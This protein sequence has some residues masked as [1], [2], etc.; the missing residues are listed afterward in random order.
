MITKKLL[1]FCHLVLAV[2]AAPARRASAAGSLEVG[3]PPP[4]PRTGQPKTRPPDKPTPLVTIDYYEP[5]AVPY[6]YAYFIDTSGQLHSMR[7]YPTRATDMHA[8][9]TSVGTDMAEPK[10]TREAWRIVIQNPT[11]LKLRLTRVRIVRTDYRPLPERYVCVWKQKG[12]VTPKSVDIGLGSTDLEWSMLPDGGQATLAPGEDPLILLA[13]IVKADPGIYR[14]QVVVDAAPSLG[15]PATTVAAGAL[16]LFVPDRTAGH[17]VHTIGPTDHTED[18]VRRI[19][20]MSPEPFRKLAADSQSQSWKINLA[21][22]LEIL[23]ATKERDDEAFLKVMRAWKDLSTTSAREGDDAESKQAN[24]KNQ[25]IDRSKVGITLAM[26]LESEGRLAEAAD[27]LRQYRIDRPED[28]MAA[29]RLMSDYLTAH[30]LNAATKLWADLQHDPIRRRLGWFA[31]GLALA[32]ATNDSR[33]ADELVKDSRTLFPDDLGLLQYRLPITATVAN[34]PALL[35]EFKSFCGY[36]DYLPD[37][38]D[39]LKF[40]AQLAATLDGVTGLPTRG[41]ADE[42]RQVL[43]RCPAWIVRL[44]RTEGRL[45]PFLPELRLPPDVST[46]KAIPNDEWLPLGTSLAMSGRLDAAAALLEKE[47][48]LRPDDPELADVLSDVYIRVGR[49]D[50][51][52]RVLEHALA[53][54]GASQELVER[55]IGKSILIAHQKDDITIVTRLYNAFGV[56]SQTRASGAPKAS[57]RIR[58]LLR[59]T[60]EIAIA[61]FE[62]LPRDFVDWFRSDPQELLGGYTPDSM[63]VVVAL[64]QAIGNQ[65]QGIAPLS[66]GMGRVPRELTTVLW[67]SYLHLNPQLVPNRYLSIDEEKRAGQASLVSFAQAT[68]AALVKNSPSLTVFFVRWRGGISFGMSHDGIDEVVDGGANIPLK[69]WSETHLSDAEGART[70]VYLVPLRGKAF[71]AQIALHEAFAAGL[72]HYDIVEAKKLVAAVTKDDPTDPSAYWLTA[73]LEAIDGAPAK[74]LAAVSRGILLDPL[75]QPLQSLKLACEEAAARRPR[76]ASHQSPRAPRRQGASTSALQFGR[77]SLGARRPLQ[78]TAPHT[79]LL[80]RP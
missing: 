64:F 76:R 28:D 18:V 55:F 21:P 41:L 80:V 38:P 9:G 74:C 27:V 42:I 1:L 53:L 11:S 59:L 66:F 56:E 31:A 78:L 73:A 39:R 65:T 57:L 37:E 10:W 79:S 4:E 49:I 33:T 40:A 23:P 71:D 3:G 22:T 63:Q 20:S 36:A 72:G 62:S 5:L 61:D 77:V 15:G 34:T 60:R 2:T 47:R 16:E 13:R 8:F 50:D 68:E 58:A 35:N 75:L 25:L 70:G 46:D 32:Q 44:V 69:R 54:K 6:G 30:D 26:I 7:A 67:R 19:L 24:W 29:V 52:Q 17:G 48:A 51:A 43:A 14:V 12:Y 45:W